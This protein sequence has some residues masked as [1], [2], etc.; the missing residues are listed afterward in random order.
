MRRKVK[1]MNYEAYRIVNLANYLLGKKDLSKETKEDVISLVE[2]VL[3]KNRMYHGFVIDADGN[4]MYLVSTSENLNTN[5][6]S[7]TRKHND[8]TKTLIYLYHKSSIS[9]ILLIEMMLECDHLWT[10]L[11]NIEL[12]DEFIK[13]MGVL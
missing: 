10:D 12:D 7:V 2:I 9:R 1:Y 4:R 5:R 11:K 6:K 3:L 8:I 13:R